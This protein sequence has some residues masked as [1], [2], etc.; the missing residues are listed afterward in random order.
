M[1]IGTNKE[2]ALG[3][4]QILFAKAESTAG[5]FIKPTATDCVRCESS[6]IKYDPG[7]ESLMEGSEYADEVERIT[8]KGKITWS[9]NADLIPSG[10]AATEPR[11]SALLTAALGTNNAGAGSTWVYSES[12]SQNLPTLSITRRWSTRLMEA[13]WGA[14]VQKMTL[15]L[16]GGKRAQIAF[17]GQAMGYRMTGS[18]Q[19][20]GA[21]VATDSMDIDAADTNL[22]G[23]NSVVKVAALDNSGAGYKIKAGT[24][25]PY[26]LESSIS[27]DDD[28]SV[29]PFA[30][31]PTWLG[32]PLHGILGSFT[33][34]SVEFPITGLDLSLDNQHS[35]NEDEFGVATFSDAIR[36]RRKVSGSLSCRVRKDLMYLI[37]NRQAFATV[38][39][40][41]TAGTSA[42]SRY[43]FSIPQAEMNFAEM[44]ASGDKEMTVQIP[45]EGLATTA[46]NN[47]LTAT[48]D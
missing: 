23:I 48:H 35:L 40:L 25:T 41:A 2:H 14:V 38:A 5:T 28:A 27:T 21:M 26:T 47:S 24:A 34:A 43:K 19:L 4:N 32:S 17:E 33:W 39:L 10:T 46:G 3:R 7:R 6:S 45:F 29:V 30:P 16:E 20:H 18:C 37:A 36:G 8:G 1:G 12:S 9:L 13:I 31:T 42:G 15:K 22:V 44:T 11:L